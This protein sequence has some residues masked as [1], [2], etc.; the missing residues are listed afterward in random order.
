[1][2]K[3]YKRCAKCDKLIDDRQFKLSVRTGTYGYVCNVCV[4]NRR[5][6]TR[7]NVDVQKENEKTR[8]ANVQS[9]NIEMERFTDDPRAVRE[10]QLET[11]RVKSSFVGMEKS[12]ANS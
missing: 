11:A 8:Q 4:K 9:D 12:Q 1:M 2:K 10:C 6:Q 7:F 3:L 5:L